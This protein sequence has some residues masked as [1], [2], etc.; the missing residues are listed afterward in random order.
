MSMLFLCTN[1]IFPGCVNKGTNLA[2]EVDSKIFD[3][4]NKKRLEVPDAPGLRRLDFYKSILFRYTATNNKI[5]AVA[6]FHKYL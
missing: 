3:R 2:A 5:I 1:Y 6:H 4:Q